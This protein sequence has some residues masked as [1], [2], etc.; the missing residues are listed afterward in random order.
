MPTFYTTYIFTLKLRGNFIYYGINT[1]ATILRSL[2]F[3][4]SKINELRKNVRVAALS[5]VIYQKNN[6]I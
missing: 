4:L 3:S 1:V 2:F 5:Y 6:L